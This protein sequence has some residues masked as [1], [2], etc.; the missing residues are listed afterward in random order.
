MFY[1]M[2]ASRNQGVP[3][4][5]AFPG[6]PLSLSKLLRLPVRSARKGPEQREDKE[7]N[8]SLFTFTVKAKAL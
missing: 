3:A 1:N 6:G 7:K 2:F 4:A 5:E 8:V